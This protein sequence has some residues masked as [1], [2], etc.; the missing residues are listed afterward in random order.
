MATV[1]IRFIANSSVLIDVG[2]RRL[3]IDGLYGNNPFFTPIR[4][5]MK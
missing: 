5:E 1:K 3:L 2:D 4:K